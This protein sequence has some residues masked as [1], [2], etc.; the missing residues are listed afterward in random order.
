MLSPRALQAYGPDQQYL[1]NC[2][3]T[4][5]RY[6]LTCPFRCG[7]PVWKENTGYLTVSFFTPAGELQTAV[8]D[9]HNVSASR[10]QTFPCPSDWSVEAD[11]KIYLAFNKTAP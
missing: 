9:R 6:G 1:C 4:A 5:D 8:V 3:V 7:E 10:G 2:G 11:L